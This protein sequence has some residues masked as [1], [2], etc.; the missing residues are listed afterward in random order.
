MRKK[1]KMGLLVS[2]L[3]ITTGCGI[4]NPIGKEAVQA[5]DKKTEEQ[6][7]SEGKIKSEDAERQHPVLGQENIDGYEGFTYLYDEVLMTVAKQNEETGK[8]ERSKLTVYVPMNDSTYLS[9]NTVSA[10]KLG[11]ELYAEL[12]PYMQSD[13]EDYLPAEN[14][15]AYIQSTFDPFF[16]TEYRDLV[17]SKAETV[18]ENAARATVEFGLYSD[19]DNSCDALFYTCYYIELENKQNL[20]V[21]VSVNANQATVKT[22]ALIE[23]LEKFYQFDIDWDADRAAKK[24]EVCIAAGERN[25]FS[26]GYLLFDLPKNWNK[27]DESMEEP[28]CYEDG[29][30][31]DFSECY[32][33]A[34]EGTDGPDVRENFSITKEHVGS[35]ISGSDLKANSEILAE[36]MIQEFEGAVEDIN[37]E[38][39]GETAIGDT[40]K[41]SY[42]MQDGDVKAKIEHYM[43]ISK[44]EL[45]YLTAT[46]V[47]ETGADVFAV[48]QDILKN[49]KLNPN[50]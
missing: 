21:M 45:I 18:G 23:E 7:Q 2:I 29:E 5:E 44:G 12:E 32:V 47:E 34:P 13:P 26:T 8:M 15:D 37:V 9:Q 43:G 22:P 42:E 10:S 46:Q 25:N 36:G 39:C 31:H 20:L 4:V 3:V 35:D 40:I 1:W 33:Y 24:K 41:L 6:T 17:V 30:F 14:L 50:Y 27:I 38:D 48:V 16:H 28:D 19:F 49:G 11:V